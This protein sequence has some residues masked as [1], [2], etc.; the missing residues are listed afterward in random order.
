MRSVPGLKRA[1]ENLCEQAGHALPKCQFGK[2][3]KRAE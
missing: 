3:I 1:A 2:A